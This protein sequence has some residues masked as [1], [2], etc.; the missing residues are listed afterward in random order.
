VNL[1]VESS[2][3][4]A[5]LFDE[6]TAAAVHAE[7][8]R[9]DVVGTSELTAVECARSIQRGVAL[10][11]V[12]EAQAAELQGMLLEAERSWHIQRLDGAVLARARQPFPAEPV[13]TLDALHLASMLQ[14]ATGMPGLVILSLD[15]RVRRNATRLGFD[16]RP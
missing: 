14:L 9:A 5:W 11:V 2:A 12:P 15:D 6:P 16:V 7:L 13:R 1:Y 4:L 10:D 3:L 8:S